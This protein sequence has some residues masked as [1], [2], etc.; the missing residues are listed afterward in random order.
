[1][2]TSGSQCERPWRPLSCSTWR[3]WPCPGNRVSPPKIHGSGIFS[4]PSPVTSFLPAKPVDADR[5]HRFSLLLAPGSRSSV[6]GALFN[7]NVFVRYF[8]SSARSAVSFCHRF[9][10]RS[11]PWSV[12]AGRSASGPFGPSRSPSRCA[13]GPVDVALVRGEPGLRTALSHE[14]EE[15]RHAQKAQA[16]RCLV[17]SLFLRKKR[18]SNLN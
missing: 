1:M 4:T 16:E 9:K 12:T 8:T 2:G 10:L 17:W 13:P 7:L 14:T 15:V 3:S 5:T 6:P 11:C 18:S